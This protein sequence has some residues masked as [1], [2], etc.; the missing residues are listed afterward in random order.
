MDGEVVR[1]LAL[2]IPLCVAA[3]GV[4][5]WAIRIRPANVTADEAVHEGQWK[6]MAEWNQRLQE[7]VEACHRE[8]DEAR[9]EAIKWKAIAEGIGQNRQDS[10][11]IAAAER[12]LEDR[13]RGE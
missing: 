6:R 12:L 5:V 13:G 2:F 7:E 1:T 4:L 9:G 3:A 8:R 11:T 10:A